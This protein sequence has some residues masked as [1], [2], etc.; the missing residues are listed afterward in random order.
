MIYDTVLTL[1]WLGKTSE[2]INIFW[3]GSNA[4]VISQFYYL[5]SEVSET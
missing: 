2:V 1:K 5:N 4:F 3:E